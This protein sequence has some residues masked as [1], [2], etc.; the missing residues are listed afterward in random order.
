MRGSDPRRTRRAVKY[1]DKKEILNVARG[2]FKI[3]GKISVTY[4]PQNLKTHCEDSPVDG[5]A[6]TYQ[7]KSSN[8]RGLSNFPPGEVIVVTVFVYEYR[9]YNEI[10]SVLKISW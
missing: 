9:S 7:T 8:S 5:V 4:P 3:P 6:I 1:V 10:A 2:G